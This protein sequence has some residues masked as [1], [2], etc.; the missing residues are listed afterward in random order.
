V[1][2][3]GGSDTL[4]VLDSTFEASTE[5]NGGGGASDVFTDAGFNEFN[6]PLT[7]T[8][9]EVIEVLPPPP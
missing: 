7:I 8:N 5:L 4:M 6:G 9:F 3:S 2:T 1:K